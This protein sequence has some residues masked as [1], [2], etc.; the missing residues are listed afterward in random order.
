MVALAKLES[1]FF[2]PICSPHVSQIRA[3]E[4]AGR[5]TTRPQPTMLEKMFFYKYC[6]TVLTLII[7][8]IDSRSLEQFSTSAGNVNQ[9]S[10]LSLIKPKDLHALTKTHS[11]SNVFSRSRN[12]DSARNSLNSMDSGPFS[13]QYI[14]DKSDGRLGYEHI[15][16]SSGSRSAGYNDVT[17]S[18]SRDRRT[19]KCTV[20]RGGSMENVNSSLTDVSNG[21]LKKVKYECEVSSKIHLK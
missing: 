7:F 21:N 11:A 4:S 15:S 9:N 19:P 5:N 16:D 14:S 8:N 10:R 6:I 20:R 13:L 1:T 12:V 2:L 18:G 17:D 3:D